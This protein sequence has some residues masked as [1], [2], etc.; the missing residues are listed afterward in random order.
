MAKYRMP[1]PGEEAL[2]RR[3]RIDPAEMAVEYSGDDCL[4]LMNYKTRHVVVIF[5]ENHGTTKKGR[6]NESY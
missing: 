1:T 5:W 2:M 4:R 6:K 3:N